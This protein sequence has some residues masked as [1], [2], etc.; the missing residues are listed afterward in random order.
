MVSHLPVNATLIFF[1]YLNDPTKYKV[2][3]PPT[4]TLTP[5]KRTFPPP[6]PY[7]RFYGKKRAKSKKINVFRTFL[8]NATSTFSHF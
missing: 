6:L 7:T 5:A 8:V 3:I 4:T 2:F 1:Y